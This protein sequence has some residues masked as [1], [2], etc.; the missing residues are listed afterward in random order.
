M[1]S[2]YGAILFSVKHS[3]LEPTNFKLFPKI[4]KDGYVPGQYFSKNSK[5]N[6]I[7]FKILKGGDYLVAELNDRGS[8]R[9]VTLV[10]QEALS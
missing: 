8:H 3:V 10:A 1:E 9:T 2:E 5:V 7:S 6:V 4:E